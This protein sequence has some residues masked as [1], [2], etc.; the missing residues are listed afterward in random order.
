MSDWKGKVTCTSTAL[1]SDWSQPVRE[2]AIPMIAKR[3]GWMTW[4]GPHGRDLTMIPC[5]P[6]HL[7][8]YPIPGHW[9]PR[10]EWAQYQSDIGLLRQLNSTSSPVAVVVA[11]GYDPIG[12]GDRKWGG[13]LLFAM[14][15]HAI[16]YLLIDHIALR[17]KPAPNFSAVDAIKGGC[18]KEFII[19][20]GE[21]DWP[22]PNHGSSSYGLLHDSYGFIRIHSQVSG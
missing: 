17:A 7:R 13:K 2:E 10:H 5:G 18:L 1:R 3:E 16:Y 11:A 8:R 12:T 6:G 9:D 19:K 14:A 21:R 4:E 20:G 22:Q 15:F